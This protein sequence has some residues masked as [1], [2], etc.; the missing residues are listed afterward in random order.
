MLRQ[1][2][3]Q[4]PVRQRVQLECRVPAAVVRL[5][6]IGTKLQEDHELKQCYKAK[7]TQEVVRRRVQL[8]G[9]CP[10]LSSACRAWTEEVREFG[11]TGL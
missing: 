10:P 9:G 7:N 8:G 1:Q 2:Q 11:M 4:Q 6:A 3:R 5:W